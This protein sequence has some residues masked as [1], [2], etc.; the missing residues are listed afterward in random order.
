MT[1][2]LTFITHLLMS[3]PLKIALQVSCTATA[4]GI[5]A[6]VGELLAVV[7]GE[8]V[9]EVEVEVTPLVVATPLCTVLLLV[10][11]LIG[12][13]LVDRDVATLAVVNGDDVCNRSPP[14]LP[15]E[16]SGGLALRRRDDDPL[17][18]L[19]G[20]A[21][22]GGKIPPFKAEESDCSGGFN[23]GDAPPS[24]GNFG[25]IFGLDPAEREPPLV[26]APLPSA[27]C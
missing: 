12:L 1:S 8:A 3:L 20:A 4:I 7:C 19:L 5:A 27:C 11:K 16:P 15:L 25:V 9:L 21:W 24:F 17:L 10:M 26:S 23:D 18:P 22:G 13:V 2:P 6:C 14:L